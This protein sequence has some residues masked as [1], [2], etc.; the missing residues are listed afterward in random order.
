MPRILSVEDDPDFQ[1]LVALAFQN[2]GYEVHYAFTGK[3]GYEKVLS[4]NPDLIL[5]DMMLPILNGVEVIKAVKKHKAA[6]D[7]P[8][9]VMTAY[10][11]DA[12]FVESSLKA[13]GVLEYIRK[14]VDVGELLRLVR[15]MLADGRERS[16]PSFKLRKGEVRIDPRFRTV[17]LRDTLV[18][19]LAP[20]RFEV[21]FLLLQTKG[22]AA[23]EDILAKVWG[24]DGG[25]KNDLEKTVQRL[26]Q[27]LGPEAG[28][29]V[30]TTRRGYE[31]V[32]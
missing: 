13:L 5:L 24:K 17:W 18:A 15:R 4:L 30:R 20:K 14:P 19:T 10:P 31:L 1:H 3:E 2:E 11:G 7:I 26:R 8:I 22:E 25:S 28:A 23:W 29:R 32:D 16:A 21:L 9:I 12:N 6:K 27:D